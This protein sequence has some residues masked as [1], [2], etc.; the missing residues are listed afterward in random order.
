MQ[1]QGDSWRPRPMR[2]TH[3]NPKRAAASGSRQAGGSTAETAC[4][5]SSAPSGCAPV[6]SR[7]SWYGPHHGKPHPHEARTK[8][9]TVAKR[10]PERRRRAAAPAAELLKEGSHL[11]CSG[12]GGGAGKH[13]EAT[14]VS[15][16][17]RGCG[18]GGY[19]AT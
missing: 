13:T 19:G 4:T 2:S 5:P 11:R 6:G 17:H 10:R 8:G 3:P 1:Q 9:A 7:L 16:C 14:C 12:R 18:R 15:A